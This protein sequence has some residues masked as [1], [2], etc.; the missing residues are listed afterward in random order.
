MEYNGYF[1]RIKY[2]SE[3]NC[4]YGTIT[5]ISDAI[6]FAGSSVAQLQEAF[7][8]AV[9]DY[10]NLCMRQ[11]KEPP[12]P[13][14]SSY[15]VR[16]NPELHEHAMLVASSQDISLNQLVERAIACYIRDEIRSAD[17]EK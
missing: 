9:E 7:S 8:A 12:K 2:D 17:A 3:D 4:F 13:Y 16:I 14:K 10:L 5:G 11:V 6:S 1:A 15:N